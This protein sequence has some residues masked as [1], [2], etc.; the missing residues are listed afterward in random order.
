LFYNEIPNMRSEV[1]I[2][3][4]QIS[5][6]LRYDIKAMILMNNNLSLNAKNFQS[7]DCLWDGNGN[8]HSE[9]INEIIEELRNS[10]KD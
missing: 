7:L 3:L 5:S 8:Y 6:T 4:H 2:M 1:I 10:F 9:L